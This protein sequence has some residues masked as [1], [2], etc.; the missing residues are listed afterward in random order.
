MPAHACNSQ[1]S[2]ACGAEREVSK[3]MNI[4]CPHCGSDVPVRGIGRKPLAI[5]V[6]KVCDVLR[7][8]STVQVAAK[9]LGCSRAYIYKVIH[10]TGMSMEE[11][12]G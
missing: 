7:N 5:P 9:E 8:S 6:S 11:V 12:R 3:N 1:R 4:K 2:Q 10:M